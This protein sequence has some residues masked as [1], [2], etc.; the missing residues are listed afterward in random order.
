MLWQKSVVIVSGRKFGT[1]CWPQLYQA[2][3]IDLKIIPSF[4]LGGG[5]VSNVRKQTEKSKEFGTQ[6]VQIYQKCK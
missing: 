1:M 2:K 4:L 6:S 3:E 5:N